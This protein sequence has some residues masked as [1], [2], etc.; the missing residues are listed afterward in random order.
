MHTF[1]YNYETTG[2]FLQEMLSTYGSLS[3][4][5]MR[6]ASHVA[7]RRSLKKCSFLTKNLN[8][9]NYDKG[10]HRYYLAF[11]KSSLKSFNRSFLNFLLAERLC[12]PAAPIASTNSANWPIV[13][14]L[15][16]RLSNTIFYTSPCIS[17]YLIFVN[18]TLIHSSDI[19]WF[20]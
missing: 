19:S 17:W 7:D 13:V 14:N 1:S 2:S 3:T 15:K 16:A 8:K 12:D 9:K 4:L 6:I 10:V 20:F 18:E 5:W 11:F